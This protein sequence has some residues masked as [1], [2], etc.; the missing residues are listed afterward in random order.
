[1]FM[2]KLFDFA[3]G[4]CLAESVVENLLDARCPGAHVDVRRRCPNPGVR[5][6]MSER[7]CPS[8]HCVGGLTRLYSLIG[9]WPSIDDGLWPSDGL[10]FAKDLTERL[11]MSVAF[12]FCIDHSKPIQLLDIGLVSIFITDTPSRYFG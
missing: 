1:M 2:I 9:V 8:A 7:R 6:P 11:V 3:L 5:A 4:E 12:C 10:V